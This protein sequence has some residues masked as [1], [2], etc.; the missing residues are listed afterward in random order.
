MKN[1]KYVLLSAILIGFTA[2]SDDDSN[3]VVIVPV[4]ELTTGELDL[5]TYVAVG[6]SFTAGYSDNALFKAAQEKSFPNILS[7]QFA[8]GGGGAFTQPLMNDNYGGLAVGGNRIFGPRL[9]FGGKTPVPI[10][11]LIGPITVSTDIAM[12]NPTGPFNNLG[13]PGAKS[14]HLLAP[15]YGNLANFPAAANPYF[16]RMTGTTPNA[17]VLELAMAQ[18]PTFFT[19]SDVGG[20]DVLGYAVS[21]GESDISADNYNP[22]TPPAVFGGSFTALVDGLTANG[23]KGVVTNVPY[24]TSLPHFTTVPHKPL[25]PTNPDFGPQIPLLNSIF[26][27]LNQIYEAVQQPNRKVVFSE[28]AASAVVIRDETLADISL[29]IEGALN[30]SPTF[31]AFIA[32]FGLPAQAA[33]LVANLLG[34]AYGQT[35][36]A[37]SGDLLVLPSSSII[38]T[39]NTGS[40]A[41]LMSMGLSQ[42]L[43]GQF[44][45]EGITFPLADKWV[46][47][48]SEQDEIKAATDAYNATI[49]SVADAKGL[50]LVDFK[51]ILQKA[52]TQGVSDGNFIFTTALVQGGLMG[53]DGIHLTS[54]GYA[55]LANKFLE[56]MDAKYGSNFIEAGVK[57]DVGAYPTNYS[58]TFQ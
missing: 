4:P 2:C 37:T 9:V 49:Q 8:Q 33:P 55:A 57:A 31:P 40:V 36:Q 41:A 51:G 34:T 17:S 19:L 1:I 46:V 23:A 25:N 14:F 16:V 47:L 53:L 20:N 43:A 54:R 32:Q 21:G 11:S 45:I 52:A 28:T 26:G 22:I 50:A 15:G 27:A 24:I 3:D 38:G 29:Q 5:T 58:H 39:V 13:V 56:A 18:N 42:Q 30:N 6:A 44:S 7:Q 48:P 35:R 10:E 12:N